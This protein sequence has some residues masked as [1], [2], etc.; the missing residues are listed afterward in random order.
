MPTVFLEDCQLYLSHSFISEWDDISSHGRLGSNSA[1]LTN[2][3]C[4]KFQQ[5]VALFDK[6]QQFVASFDT[7]V[8]LAPALSS[9]V[10]TVEEK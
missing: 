4:T 2:Y 5:F 8:C 1:L 7:L 10:K 3:L 6:I 9:Q